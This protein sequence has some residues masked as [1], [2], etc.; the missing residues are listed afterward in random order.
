MKNTYG[1][2]PKTTTIDNIFLT[3]SKRNQQLINKFIEYK[4]GSVSNT[5]LRLL[6]NSL[7]KFADLIEIDFD[8]A[9]RDEITMGWNRI[10]SSTEISDKSKQDEYVHIRQA[11]KYW[12][13][14]DEEMP[15]I[16]RSMRRP[17]IR[18]R[19]R[20]PSE[21]PSEEFIYN[22]I[23]L[24][25]NHRDKFFIS[26]CAFDG[27]ARPVELRSLKWKDLKKDE[28]GY[29]FNVWVAKKS[30][31]RETRPIRIIFSEPYFVKW[32]ENYP[33]QR[34]E[35]NYVF[36]DLND[37]SRPIT[38]WTV[39]NLFKRLRKRLNVQK[40]SAYILRHYALNRMSKDPDMPPAVL[41][42]L[43]GHSK[44]S[45]IL[46]EYQHINK[47]DLL[48]IQIPGTDNKSMSKKTFKLQKKPVE[49]PH[50]QKSNPEDAEICGFC[51]FALSQ[52]NQANT[53][54]LQEYK[55]RLEL[56][57]KSNTNLTLLCNKLTQRLEKQLN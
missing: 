28:H 19:L 44:N 35:D 21:M 53:N 7:V 30:G 1:K 18:G 49:C 47:D 52:K 5:R 54:E 15:R 29:Y 20:I 14:D 34:L 37:P 4:R 39:T 50:C 8:K 22:A 16:V 51:N 10:Y 55:E 3:L 42:V 25:R 26:Y 56:L 48:N 38:N 13:G 57:E 46:S 23:R 11:F 33:G 36:S 27:G 43:A 6:F 31:D 2:V 40:F 24:C 12:F 41:R 17:K 45:T 32:L 9:T